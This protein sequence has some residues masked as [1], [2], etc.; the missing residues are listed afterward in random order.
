MRLRQDPHVGVSD[1]ER[2]PAPRVAMCSTPVL[3]IPGPKPHDAVPP[4]DV[5]PGRKAP[6]LASRMM[7]GVRLVTKT[8]HS[9]DPLC[10]MAAMSELESRR[11]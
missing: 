10:V 7:L 11:G 6:Q 3:N 4:G 1:Q 8:E 2:V 9:P 5:A